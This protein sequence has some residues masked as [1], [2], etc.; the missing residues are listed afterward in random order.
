MWVAASIT[1][2]Q[3]KG[4]FSDNFEA[5]IANALSD[6]QTNDDD[7]FVGDY[8][9]SLGHGGLKGLNGTNKLFG[10]VATAMGINGSNRNAFLIVEN[11]DD[12]GDC[13]TFF[14]TDFNLGRLKGMWVV[15]KGAPYTHPSTLATAG[16]ATIAAVTV[17]TGQGQ[18]FT[19]AGASNTFVSRAAIPTFNLSDREQVLAVDTYCDPVSGTKPITIAFG[20]TFR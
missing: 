14:S 9:I 20:Y 10:T 1:K 16:A 5:E 11:I 18:A 7:I 3:V 17:T 8:H 6:S 4:K 15:E 19:L 13:E 2:Y 12:S